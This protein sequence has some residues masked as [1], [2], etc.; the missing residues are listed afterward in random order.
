MEEKTTFY[1]S[2]TK[3][4]MLQAFE[5]CMELSDDGFL[6]VDPLGKIAFINTAYCNYIGIGKEETIGKPVLDCINSSKMVGFATN[7]SS[8]PEKNVLHKVSD[9]QFSDKEHYCI[10]SRANFSKDGKSLGAVAQIK[11]VRNTIKLY[12]ALKN[13]YSQLEYYKSEI[14]RIANERYSP[15][16]ILGISDEIRDVKDLVR[17]ASSN[18]F[19]VLITGETGTGKEVIAD[20]VHYASNRKLKPF[21]R[22]NCAAIP[23]ELMESELFGYE[24][25]SFTGAKRG[26]KK[27]KFE[28]ADGGTIFLDE[29]GELPMFMQAKLLR[30]LQE[31]EIERVGGDKPIP[32]NVRVLSATNKDLR[33]EIEEKHFREDLYYRLNVIE[34]NVPPLRSRT[35]DI[36]LFIDKFLRDINEEYHSNTVI[37]NEAKELL[38]HYEWPGNVRE[39]K[40][41]LERCYTLSENGIITKRTIPT[42]IIGDVNFK[43]IAHSHYSNLNSTLDEVE[44][45]I[46]LKEISST[47]GNLRQAAINLGIHRTTLYKKMEKLGIVREDANLY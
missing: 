17:R 12:T 41:T 30:A 34:I 23:T 5:A 28:L 24:E 6:I 35:M 21:I 39:L 15:D 3:D 18:D 40:N 44:R 2:Y 14:E 46:I 33:K 13:T 4:T 8:S 16:N 20:A 7:I 10:V 47:Q 43:E 29:I 42:N 32:V 22:I 37:D 1:G 31:S 11:F 19:P 36:P 9:K 25:G 26:G 45:R 38:V 27:G